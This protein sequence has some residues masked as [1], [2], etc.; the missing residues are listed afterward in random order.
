MISQISPFEAEAAGGCSCS[1]VG[2]LAAP[3]CFGSALVGAAN[4]LARFPA[5]F[6]RSGDV[7][8]CS[9]AVRVRLRF[10]LAVR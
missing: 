3:T 8:G 1:P 5:S 7:A 4:L 2:M 9:D 10:V 6:S